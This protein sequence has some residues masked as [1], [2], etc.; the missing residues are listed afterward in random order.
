[1]ERYQATR[2]SLDYYQSSALVNAQLIL[3]QSQAAFRGGEIN[4]AEYLMGLRNALSVQENYLSTLRDYNQSI[5]YIDY[6]S[7]NP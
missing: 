2:S 1:L 4:Y 7:G 6:L 5:I 3:T